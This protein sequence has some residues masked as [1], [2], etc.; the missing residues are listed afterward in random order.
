MRVPDN[1]TLNPHS[2]HL[3][4]NSQHGQAV[5]LVLPSGRPDII[6]LLLEVDQVHLHRELLAVDGVFRSCAADIPPVEVDLT[7]LVVVVEVGSG[8]ARS[9]ARPEQRVM[10]LMIQSSSHPTTLYR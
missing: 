1:Y 5:G 3:K 9:E 8:H 6:E 4:E 7:E 2:S 10:L